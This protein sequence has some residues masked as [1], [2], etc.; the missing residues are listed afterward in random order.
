MLGSAVQNIIALSDNVFLY[1]SAEPSDFAAIAIV[2][3]FY[4]II[5]A[6]GFGFSK[7]G[8]IIIA[9]R[10]GEGKP[11]EAGRTFYAMLYF[12]LALALVMFLFMK[13]GSYY[14]FSVFVDSEVYL[15]KCLE[16]LDYRSYGV[17]FS[18]AGVA[19]VALYTGIARPMFIFIDTIV[20]AVVNIVFNYGLIFGHLG[21]P[22]MG[23]AG[24]GLASTIAEVVAFIIFVIY[25]LFDKKIRAY[26]LFALPKIDIPLISTQL[27]LATPIVA[28]VV[29][30]LGSWFLFIILIENMGDRPLKI[31]NLVRIVYLV[32][33][34]PA[35][36]FATG[37]NT[38]VSNFIGQG[39][40]DAVLPIIWKT[41]KLC[42][43][44]TMLVTLP[45]VLAP[46][47]ILYPLFGSE[48]MSLI[49]EAQPL[50]LV[51]IA[52]LTLF[53]VG[54]IYFNGLAGAGATYFGLKI[55]FVCASVYLGYTYLVIKVFEGGLALAWASEILYW[56]IMMTLI[57]PYLKSKKWYALKV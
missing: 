16:Y 55:Q 18:Y 20:L 46:K 44:S 36:G 37:I 4:L 35:W 12:E 33:S 32:L 5:A 41:A 17:F 1:H 19:I 15:I 49:A 7:G 21:L 42:W 48:D 50:F 53:S 25:I 10:V 11:E 29:V 38:L 14:F 23:I 39:R 40:R 52:I 22:K 3:V 6:I 13:F 34:I 2:G 57:I 30:G 26:R 31:T 9:R 28:Q 27:R 47:Y 45:V 54:S 24:A 43:F 8:Q 51:L 56:I